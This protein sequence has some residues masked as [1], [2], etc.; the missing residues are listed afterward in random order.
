MDVY[1][2]RGPT[3]DIYLAASLRTRVGIGMKS[4]QSRLAASVIK[5]TPL[6]TGDPALAELAIYPSDPQWCSE[7]LADF[8]VTRILPHL[9]ADQGLFELRNLIIQPEAV[10]LNMHHIPVR[11]ITPEAVQRWISDLVELAQIAE[12]LPPPNKTEAASTLEQRSRLNRG[13]FTFPAVL[14]TLG[15]VG[16]IT[17]CG[18]AAAVA[19]ILL[20]RSGY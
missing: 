18:I 20:S 14:I 11:Q 1:F 3:L 8:S 7:L 12:S 15:I 5:R 17:M 6:E 10:Q 2:Y 19:M 4:S 9:M 13:S 16:A